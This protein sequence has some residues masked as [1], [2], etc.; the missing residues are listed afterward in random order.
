MTTSPSYKQTG[1]IKWIL[2]SAKLQPGE[3]ITITMKVGSECSFTG[4][5]NNVVD[6]AGRTC[7]NAP[8]GDKYYLT[9]CSGQDVKQV[10]TTTNRPDLT[11]DK[12]PYYW[13]AEANT[14]TGNTI[15]WTI[16]IHNSGNAP[17]ARTLISDDLPPYVTYGTYAVPSG[18]T[19][20]WVSPPN[21]GDTAGVVLRWVTDDPID[22]GD[23]L[24]L[25]LKGVIDC[26]GAPRTKENIVNIQTGC[27][28]TTDTTALYDSC[29]TAAATAD[30]YWQ[31]AEVEASKFTLTQNMANFGFCDT[32]TLTGI[33]LT[34]TVDVRL[35]FVDA[36]PVWTGSTGDTVR[37]WNIGTLASGVSYEI[38]L[39]VKADTDAS[40]HASDIDNLASVTSLDPQ[41]TRHT[42]TDAATIKT[43]KP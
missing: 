7:Y 4:P 23:T 1:N 43:V 22:A 31:M 28:D 17:T 30:P 41:A 21:P 37:T 20:N 38:R 33:T 16:I 11:I 25:I 19:L 9:P 40:Y 29:G 36:K 6:I 32:K 39:T 34:D 5:Q 2:T 24:T 8:A 15:A 42:D 18:Q 26:D 35:T 12:V 14:V 3:T 27:P 13:P 10:T